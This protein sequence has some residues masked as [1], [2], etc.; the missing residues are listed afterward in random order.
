MSTVDP[1]Q[2][3]RQHEA[4]RLGSTSSAA[5]FVVGLLILFIGAA[6]VVRSNY[7][8]AE[9]AVAG[10]EPPSAIFLMPAGIVMMILGT[11]IS[12]VGTYRYMGRWAVAPVVGQGTVLLAGFAAGAWWGWAALAKPDWV[13]ILIPVALTT[14]AV[15]ALGLGVIMRRRARTRRSVLAE[16]VVSG[17]IVPGVI[18]NIPEIEA[19]SGGL[20][21]TVTVKFT[22]TAGVARWVQKVGQWRRPDLPKIGDGTAVLFDPQ[23]PGNTARIRVGPPGS[24]TV[25]AFSL[26]HS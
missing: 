25:E 9:M 15:L 12:I 23:D 6:I 1:I 4:A 5:M 7:G 14:L 17:R 21:G 20:I 26:W 19:G 13:W 8:F 22:D 3:R 11:L 24:A 16:L 2:V 18:A 10:D